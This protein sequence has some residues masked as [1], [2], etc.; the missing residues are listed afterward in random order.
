[1]QAFWRMTQIEKFIGR[2]ITIRIKNR[3]YINVR[4]IFKWDRQYKT[5]C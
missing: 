5:L 1:M 4:G 3:G 2:I